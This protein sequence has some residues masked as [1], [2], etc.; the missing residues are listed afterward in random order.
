M[1]KYWSNELVTNLQRY[2]MRQLIHAAI[3]ST[4]LSATGCVSPPQLDPPKVQEVA[5]QRGHYET[6]YDNIIIEVQAVKGMKPTRPTFNILAELFDEYKIC[7]KENVLVI[8]KYPVDYPESK[9]PGSL[10][11]KYETLFRAVL[12]TNPVDRDFAIFVSYLPGKYGEPKLQTVAGLQYN[13]SSIAVFGNYG[14]RSGANLLL[15]EFGHLIGMVDRR[16]RETPPVNP[17]RPN[18]CND[19]N[20]V[21]YWR[22]NKKN[23]FCDIC[24]ADILEIIKL[25][26]KGVKG[27]L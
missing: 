10:V 16:N 5:Q 1:A 14:G 24:A 6:L 20:C 25:K 8:H 22:W 27:P 21:M 12:D 3:L 7:K 17:K 11:R 4:F 9:W 15:H 26:N 19:K 13:W 18:H 2:S 23:A